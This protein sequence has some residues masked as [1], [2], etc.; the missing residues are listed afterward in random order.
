MLKAE[1]FA[2]L[3][4]ALWLSR[5]GLAGQPAPRSFSSNSRDLRDWIAR[6]LK[7]EEDIP[8]FEQLLRQDHDAWGQL[9]Q[10]W[11]TAVLACLEDLVPEGGHTAED[12]LTLACSCTLDADR[13]AVQV[14][15]CS[16]LLQKQPCLGNSRQPLRSSLMQTV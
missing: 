14:K 5:K 4:V 8:L 11:Q 1:I 16:V 13:L 10:G 6:D 3:P 7:R 12:V 15:G 2:G 9:C